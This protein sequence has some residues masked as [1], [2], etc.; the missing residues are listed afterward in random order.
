VGADRGLLPSAAACRLQVDNSD[1]SLVAAQRY[2]PGAR[3]PILHR[4]LQARDCALLHGAGRLPMV[5]YMYARTVRG[6]LAIR[7]LVRL[8]A[9]FF[10]SGRSSIFFKKKHCY[11]VS[12]LLLCPRLHCE[13]MRQGCVALVA[14]S[15]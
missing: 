4:R 14:S 2:G 6:A 15:V 7:K 9:S 13:S 12:P 1:K 11:S 5:M 8:A 10:S 3:A